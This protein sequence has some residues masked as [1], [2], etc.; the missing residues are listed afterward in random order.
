MPKTIYARLKEDHDEMK[1]MLDTLSE[2]FD[3]GVFD[4]FKKELESHARAEEKVLYEKVVDDDSVHSEVL[5]G[6]EEHHV[7]D[8]L[9]REL[10]EN[11]K[12]TD[13]WMAKLSVLKESLEHHIE[14]EE[15][16]MFPD[17]QKILPQQRAEEMTS[18]FEQVKASI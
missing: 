5:E 9:L 11:N 15:G 7:A 1:Q 10:I 18:E 8:L 6:Y 4:D 17:I 16:T 14:E 3:D 12:G 2:E 13:R